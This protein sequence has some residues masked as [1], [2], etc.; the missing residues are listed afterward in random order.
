MDLGL[1]L[2]GAGFPGTPAHTAL[3][4]TLGFGRLAEE[5]GLPGVWLAEHHFI[6]YGVCPSATVAA[7]V[8][9]GGT[10]RITVGAAACVLSNRQPVA[11]GEEAVML[12]ALSGGRFRLGVARGG[13]WVD[14]EVFDTG[15]DRFEHGFAESLDVLCDWTSGKPR[16]AASGRF[17]EFREVRVVPRPE[18]PLPMWV[19]ATSVST[20]DIA[21]ARG[22]PLI[23][24]MHI[25]DEEKAAMLDRWR[26]IAGEHGH[27]PGAAEH[28]AAHLCHVDDS[29]RRAAAALR[30]AMPGWIAEG[31]A[32]YVR[33]D[34]TPGPARDPDAYVESLIGMHPV[35]PPGYCAGVLARSAERTGVRHALLMVEG[36]GDPDVTGAVIR[37]LGEEVAPLLG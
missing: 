26:R 33:V 13:P 35:G 28:A 3:R 31:T 22:I 30:S 27:D 6:S 36:T 7:G 16:V 20:V 17:H 1:F 25:G 37:R 19:A 34:G 5:A 29:R 23:L 15:L 2:V 21:A 9:L 32:G 24:G 14:L 8:L 18:G 12:D 11:L 10:S 4:N